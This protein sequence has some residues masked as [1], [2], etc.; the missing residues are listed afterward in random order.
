MNPTDWIRG[1]EA[2]EPRQ[3]FWCDFA[4]V[5]L[6][7]DP[8]EMLACQNASH[9]LLKKEKASTMPPG[10]GTSRPYLKMVSPDECCDLW[11]PTP[12][13]GCR[14]RVMEACGMF[15]ES[16]EKRHAAMRAE[17][18]EKKRTRKNVNKEKQP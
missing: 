9:V 16:L 3:C 10:W 17:R 4:C 6:G 14:M 1:F 15:D 2:S 8:F 7:V 5:V 11:A 18:R 12:V 13:N